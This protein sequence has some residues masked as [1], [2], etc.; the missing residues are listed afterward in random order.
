MVRSGIEKKGLDYFLNLRYEISL[1]QHSDDDQTYWVAEIPDL[2]GCVADGQT[3]DEAVKEL[4]EAKRLWIETQIEDGFEVPEPF[5]SHDFSGK[6]TLRIPKSLHRR[7]AKEARR[8]GVSL[9]HYIVSQLASSVT[10]CEKSREISEFE[11]K[12]VA[13][14]QGMFD[15]LIN[16]QHIILSRTGTPQISSEN[17]LSTGITDP[18]HWQLQP[19][20]VGQYHPGSDVFLVTDAYTPGRATFRLDRMDNVNYVGQDRLMTRLTEHRLQPTESDR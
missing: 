13:T 17:P 18:T 11:D 3:P 9:N 19:D 14:N 8:E 15:R 1:S 6:L 10:A 7:L 5:E 2:P 16:L 20:I 4:E 12:L